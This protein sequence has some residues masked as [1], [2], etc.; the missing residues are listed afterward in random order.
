MVLGKSVLIHVHPGYHNAQIVGRV[1]SLIELFLL[2]LFVA[3]CLDQTLHM[4]H[5][6]FFADNQISHLLQLRSLFDSTILAGNQYSVNALVGLRS[7]LVEYI[8]LYFGEQQRQNLPLDFAG[9]WA[10]FIRFVGY[11]FGQKVG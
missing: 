11:D 1:D 2:A 10:E 8:P 5:Y 7:L 3:Q 4:K 9:C 6:L